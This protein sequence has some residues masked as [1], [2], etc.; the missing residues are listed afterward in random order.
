MLSKVI[1]EAALLTDEE[2]SRRRRWRSSRGGLRED[3]DGFGP[4]VRLLRMSN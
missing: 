1:I 3:V 4:E 2:K